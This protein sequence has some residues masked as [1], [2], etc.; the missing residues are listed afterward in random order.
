MPHPNDFSKLDGQSAKL[1][2][3]IGEMSVGQKK[4]MEICGTHTMAIAKAG[5]KQL[6]PPGVELISGPGCP[7]CVTPS[8]A[9][10]AFLELS[11]REDVIIASYG[12][13]LRL[14][15]SRKGDNLLRRRA[16][17]ADVRIVYSPMDA[18]ELAV[19]NPQKQVVFLGVGFE[20]TA[21]G[22]AVSILSSA[23]QGIENYSVF[24]MLK[25]APPAVRA[26]LKDDSFEIDAFLCPGH[27]ASIIGASGFAFLPSEFGLPAVVAGFETADILVALYRILCQLK[28]GEAALSNEYSR[29]V[30]DE[31]NPAALEVINSVFTPCDD[32]WRGLGLI[33]GSGLAINDAFGHYDAKRRFSIEA[34]PAP[35]PAG[36]R[37]GE[38]ICGKLTPKACPLFG[39]VCTPE[40]PVGPCMV[41]GEGSC[42]AAYK[43]RGI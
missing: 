9:I 32:D 22:T 41:S 3:A 5:I 25:C 42:A 43:Y 35:E 6:L 36:C 23:E 28:T 37:C 27:V 24:S 30:Q 10:D 17:G 29:A 11:S 7:V 4:I 20:T 15:G 21:P 16:K 26:L 1:A 8:G 2:A 38:V 18:L 12:D 34:I 40:D 19:N 31:G 39:N 14:P 33:P 13:M